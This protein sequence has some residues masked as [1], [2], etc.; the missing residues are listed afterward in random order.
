MQLGMQASMPP[1]QLQMAN[2][3][4][5]PTE[6]RM[7]PQPNQDQLQQAKRIGDAMQTNVKGYLDPGLNKKRKT[8]RFSIFLN[9]TFKMNLLFLRTPNRTLYA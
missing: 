9:I 5:P 6:K 3:P 8:S 2:V 7:S 1:H 4:S